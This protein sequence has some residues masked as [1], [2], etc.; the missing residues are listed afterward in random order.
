MS[1]RM[2]DLKESISS[3]NIFGKIVLTP[4]LVLT[5]GMYALFNILFVKRDKK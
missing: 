1:L 5:F 4:I 3:L 2:D